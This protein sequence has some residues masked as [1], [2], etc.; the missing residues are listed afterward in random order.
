MVSK[1]D[2]LG[3]WGFDPGFGEGSSGLSCDYGDISFF[4]HS[5]SSGKFIFVYDNDKGNRWYL[6]EI[7]QINTR[8]LS[9]L[10]DK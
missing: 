10:F 5:I 2:S 3:F 4:L 6:Q 7:F 1:E 8:K 9:I